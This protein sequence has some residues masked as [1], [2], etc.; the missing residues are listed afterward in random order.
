MF[1]FRLNELIQEI[2]LLDTQYYLEKNLMEA[3]QKEP[4][5]IEIFQNALELQQN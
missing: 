4:K 3:C 1:K 5:H 2:K